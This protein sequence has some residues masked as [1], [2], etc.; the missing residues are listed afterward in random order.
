MNEAL[1]CLCCYFLLEITHW[2]TGAST[3]GL[4][5]VDFPVINTASAVN[6]HRFKW[7]VMQVNLLPG[8]FQ[9]VNACLWVV[10]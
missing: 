10:D 8:I 2:P 4:I 3:S 1:C 5:V 7:K 9:R 6:T